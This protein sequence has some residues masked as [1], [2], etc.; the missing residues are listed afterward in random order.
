MTIATFTFSAGRVLAR[1]LAPVLLLAL[2][3]SAVRAEDCPTDV[4]NSSR[5]RR[6]LAKDWFHKAETAEAASDPVNALKAYQCSLKVVPHAFTAY[7]LARLAEKTGDLE[8]AVEAYGKYLNLAPEAPDRTEVEGKMTSL[9]ARIAA[10]R[11]D[12][13]AGTPPPPSPDPAST[14]PVVEA[15]R[16]QERDTELPPALDENSGR[17]GHVVSPAVYVVGVVG[18]AALVGGVV[19]NIGARAKMDDCFAL[20]NTQLQTAKDACDAAKPRAYG[21]Y[22]LFGVAAAAVV[23]DAFLLFANSE[24]GRASSNQVSFAVTPDGASVLGRFRF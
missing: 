5:D 17:H 23:A 10:S 24:E 9:S 22:A 19:L 11:N 8:L 13:A 6:A 1:L 21:S 15:P 12:T 4:P 20:V 18:V 14:T 16:K 7:N 2:S 3:A